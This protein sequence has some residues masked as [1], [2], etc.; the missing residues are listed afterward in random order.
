MTIEQID[1]NKLLIILENDEMQEYSLNFEQ[2]SLSDRNSREVLAKLLKA[3]GI[4][5]GLEISGKTLLVEA[6]SHTSGCM[7]IITVLSDYSKEEQHRYK[8]KKSR[9]AIIYSFDESESF[10]SAVER[11]YI[12]GYIFENSKAYYNG[13]YTLVMF[14]TDKIPL[15]AVAIL[16]EYGKKELSGRIN[17]ARL[18]ESS[19][20]ISDCH[21]ILTI[22]S[23]LIRNQ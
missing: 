12:G 3:A 21:A 7:L 23:Q 16:E 5:K 4:C 6:M 20:I 8:I 14:Y 15:N 19:K 18:E 22:G 10:L 2:M 9:G 1:S 11:L 17:L 13:E